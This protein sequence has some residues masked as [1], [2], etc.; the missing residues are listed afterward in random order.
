V[1]GTKVDEAFELYE[2]FKKMMDSRGNYD[3][4]EEQLEDAIAFVG[5]SRFVNRIKCALLGWEAFRD[6]TLRTTADAN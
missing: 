2:E 4:D 5:V 6:A 1:I 3:P